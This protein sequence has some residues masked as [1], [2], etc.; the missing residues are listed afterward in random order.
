MWTQAFGTVLAT[1]IFSYRQAK[2]LVA[3]KM[4]NNTKQPYEC[5]IH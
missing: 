2:S 4:V 1:K 5:Y 3:K